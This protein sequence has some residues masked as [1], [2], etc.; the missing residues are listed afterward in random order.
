MSMALHDKKQ[1]P[2]VPLWKSFSFA[3]AGIQNAILNERNIRIHLFISALVIFFSISFSITK[4]EWLFVLIAIG[5][6]ISL[7]LI[8]TAIERLVD[9]V[10]LEFHPLAKQA[11]DLAAGAVF[12]YAIFSVIVGIII[13]APKL[14][15]AFF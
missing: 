11:K 2:Y 8:N 4:V 1:R 6:M 12:I 7:E 9:L 3:I 13:F 10:T 15:K 14:Y 5:G